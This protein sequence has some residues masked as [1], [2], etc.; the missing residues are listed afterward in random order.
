MK[1]NSEKG[2]TK[3]KLLQYEIVR[4]FHFFQVIK[5][6]ANEIQISHL[7]TSNSLN[8]LEDATSQ[9][10]KRE[11]GDDGKNRCFLHNQLHGIGQ[12]PP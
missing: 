2:I 3:P 1:I 8:S 4:I 10:R 9:N 12:L 5:Y 6:M 11:Y 7:C